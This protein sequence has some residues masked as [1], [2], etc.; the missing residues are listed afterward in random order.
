MLL[1]FG[2]LYK[3]VMFYFFFF[4]FLKKQKIDLKKASWPKFCNIIFLFFLK[5]GQVGPV[6]KQINLVSPKTK[7]SH[8]NK[9]LALYKFVSQIIAFQHSSRPIYNNK[10]SLLHEQN[11]VNIE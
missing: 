2:Y 8:K 6:E 1:G 9:T 11:K 7:I 10:L 4:F 3:F 5:M